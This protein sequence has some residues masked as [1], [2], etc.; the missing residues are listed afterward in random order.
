MKTVLIAAL[1]AALV[2]VG[3]FYLWPTP[4]AP[5]DPT[6]QLNGFQQQLA[7]LKDKIVQRPVD[8]VVVLT[9][10]GAQCKSQTL[11]HGYAYREQAVRWW[12][13][14][15]N[16]NLNGREVEIR[17]ADGNTPLDIKL[18][19]HLTF[20]KAKV[21]NNAEIALYKYALWAVGKAGDYQLE[22]PELE[23]GDF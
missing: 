23:I 2:A 10:T 16:C 6:A 11:P 5:P 4:P 14:N 8:L 18:P 19:K 9:Q 21:R 22:D 20:I 3:I 7:D 1:T 12:I 15:A 17:F 13:I